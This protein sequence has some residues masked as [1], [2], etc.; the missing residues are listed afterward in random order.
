MAGFNFAPIAVQPQAQTSLSDMLNVARGAQAYQQAQQINPLQA[1][2]AAQALELSRIET[3]KA[4]RT[5]E[6]EISSKESEAKRLKLVAEQAGVDVTNHYA[7]IARG[8]YGGLLTDPDFVKGNS[9]KMVE[10][11]NKA[12]NFLEDTG[13][14]M[15]DSKMHEDL[16]KEAK[17]NP[18]QAY[19]L[20]K[21][22]I[23]QGG[24]NAEQ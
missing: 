1:Q 4:R 16:I 15:H 24:S 7:N 20:I 23:Q 13:I 18:A 22:G 5:L 21:N 19:Q 12:K 11:L 9:E 17:S 2:Q 3:E 14:P 8:V 6:P 10:K